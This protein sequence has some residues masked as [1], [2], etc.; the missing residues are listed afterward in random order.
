MRAGMT[1]KGFGKAQTPLAVL[2]SAA[3][4]RTKRA[5]SREITALI[6]RPHYIWF[7]GCAEIGF[8]AGR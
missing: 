4:C 3:L 1:S 5:Q 2:I 8:S 6:F 7:E